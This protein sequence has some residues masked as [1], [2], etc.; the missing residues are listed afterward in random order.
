VRTEYG[1]YYRNY[2]VPNSTVPPPTKS[3]GNW[4]NDD[5]QWVVVASDLL[6]VSTRS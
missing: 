1:Y 6:L 2:D 5:Q 4:R 3:R